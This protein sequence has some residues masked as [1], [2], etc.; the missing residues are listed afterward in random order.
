[1]GDHTAH[2]VRTGSYIAVAQRVICVHIINHKKIHVRLVQR[3]TN[4]I[5]PQ[6]LFG[7]EK[8]IFHAG[9]QADHP[10]HRFHQIP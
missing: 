4:M 7:D 3:P 8:E 5:T 1:M 6:G 10:T 9:P 2:A